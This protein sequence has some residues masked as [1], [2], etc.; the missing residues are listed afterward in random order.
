MMRAVPGKKEQV[1]YAE[2]EYE[3][4]RL[5]LENRHPV[6]LEFLR[7]ETAV[8]EKILEQLTGKEELAES[9]RLRV[10]EIQKE[11]ERLHRAME[12]YE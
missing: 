8:R 4:G 1:P 11:I 10:G 7:R 6:L 3:Y 12:R 9:A 2:E 5:L